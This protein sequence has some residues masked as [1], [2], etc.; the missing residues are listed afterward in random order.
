MLPVKISEVYDLC[1]EVDTNME[2]YQDE[3]QH[4]LLR[5]NHVKASYNLYSCEHTCTVLKHM[6][7]KE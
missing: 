4:A 1:E 7:E 3:S 6:I 5:R 2:Q